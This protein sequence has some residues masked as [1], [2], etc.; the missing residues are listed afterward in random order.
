MREPL[1]G[2][3]NRGKGGG[4]GEGEAKHLYEHK[5]IFVT[6]CALVAAEQSSFP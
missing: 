2:G 1:H 4:V 6:S 5:G 3:R